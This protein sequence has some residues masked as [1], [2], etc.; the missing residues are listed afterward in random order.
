MLMYHIPDD[1]N[2]PS[3]RD[4]AN[5]STSYALPVDILTGMLATHVQW[6]NQAAEKE[7]KESPPVVAYECTDFDYETFG[8]VH[9]ILTRSYVGEEDI[10]AAK[11]CLDFFGPFSRSDLLVSLSLE[12]TAKKTRA[13]KGTKTPED[14]DSSLI[15]CESEARMCAVINTALAL[16][17]THYVPFKMLF[18]EGVLEALCEVD[19]SAVEVPMMPAACL[20]GD[21]NNIFCLRKIVSTHHVSPKTLNEIHSNSNVF[22]SND[23]KISNTPAG[24]TIKVEEVG[25]QHDYTEN[26]YGL[27]LKVGLESS[28]EIKSTV[29]QSVL[30]E[31][32]DMIDSKSKTIYL[33]GLDEGK[34]KE[35]DNGTSFFHRNEKGEIAFTAKEAD[36]ASDFIAS[37]N[38]EDRIKAELQKK[39][40][41]LPQETNGVQA[42]FCNE[43]VYGKVNILWVCGVIR[44]E[45]GARVPGSSAAIPSRFNAWPSTAANKATATARSQI[46]KRARLGYYAL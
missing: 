39:S 4:V 45:D 5:A 9:K 20:F 33:P 42:H 38:L 16:G 46:N 1:N 26:G 36:R 44:M 31:T 11:S 22:N 23:T 41:V 30:N 18:V 27:G 29:L 2:M 40:F 8:V 10:I 25:G 3:V 37:S 21:H 24:T 17:E 7:G 12:T 43:S 28:A 14:F 34:E 35:N 15:I 19:I 6:A 32:Y 13:G